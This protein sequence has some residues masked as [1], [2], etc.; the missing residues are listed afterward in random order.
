MDSPDALMTVIRQ[1][2]ELGWPAIVLIFIFV[3]W[4]RIL[5]VETE[6][7]DCLRK[8]KKDDTEG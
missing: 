3:L 7:H 2:L 5:A 4:R 8:T 6:L 1:V